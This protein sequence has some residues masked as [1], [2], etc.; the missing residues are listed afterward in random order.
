MG[1]PV[2]MMMESGKRSARRIDFEMGY[3]SKIGP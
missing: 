1:R 3:V 2:R